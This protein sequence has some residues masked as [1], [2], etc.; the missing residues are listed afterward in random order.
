VNRKLAMTIPPMIIATPASSKEPR[1]LVHEGVGGV[2][3]EKE[4][5]SNGLIWASGHTRVLFREIEKSQF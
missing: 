5:P 1:E 2:G 4:T 3:H